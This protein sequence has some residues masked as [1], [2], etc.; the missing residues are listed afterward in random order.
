M[1]FFFFLLLSLLDQGKGRCPWLVMPPA[2]LRAERMGV[3]AASFQDKE[4]SSATLPDAR[5]VAQRAGFRSQQWG[6]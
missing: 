1:L 2:A 4:G 6:G 3:E 5:G